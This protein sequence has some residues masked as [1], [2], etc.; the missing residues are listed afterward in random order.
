MWILVAPNKINRAGELIMKLTGRRGE[1]ATSSSPDADDTDCGSDPANGSGA[2][3]CVRRAGADRR[4]SAVTASRDD[5]S[6]ELI[7]RVNPFRSWSSLR[8]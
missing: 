2:G 4:T 8:R 1:M 3:T 6:A 7:L 5:E